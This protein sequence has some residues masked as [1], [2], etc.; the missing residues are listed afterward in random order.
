MDQ[1][2]AARTRLAEVLHQ[3]WGYESFLPLQEPAMK[4]V[5]AHRD[6]LVVL[7]T[8][9]GKSLCFQAPAMCLE[10]LAVVVSPLISL[11]KDQ[12]DAL[13]GC[14]VPAACVH[15]G[16]TPE[17]RRQIR[18]D[19]RAERLRLLYVA[20]ERLVQER[21]IEFLK[22]R[23]ISLIAIDEA[24]C[25]S[26]WGHDFRPEYRQLGLL[27]KLLPGV[28]IHAY[29]ATATERV[30]HDIVQQLALRD[31]EVLVGSFDRPNLV[32]RVERRNDRLSQIR[33]VMDRHRGSSGVVYCITRKE[34]DQTSE[35]LVN[36]GYR[37]RPYHAGMPDDDRRQNQDAFIEEKVETIVATVAFGMGIDKSNVRYVI[38]AGMPKSLEHYQQESG[39]AGRDGLE[40]ECCLIYSPQDVMTW[41]FMLDKDET[42]AEARRAA[43]RS[44]DAMEDFCTG[45]VCRHRALVEHF[46]QTYD[47]DNCG[48]CD[49]CLDDV[50]LVEDAVIVGQKILSCV[51]RLQQRFGGEYTAQVLAGSREQRILQAGHDR[52]STY[53]LLATEGKRAV[54]DWIEQLTAQGYLRKAG[55]FNV[56]EVTSEGRRLL[57]GETAPRLL[58]PAKK[59]SKEGRAATPDVD[60]WEGVDHGLFEALRALR[61]QLAIDQNVPP[62]VVFHDTSL[63]DMARRRPSTLAGFRQV[64]GVGEKKLADY[65]EVFVRLIAEHCQAQGLPVDITPPSATPRP[66][67]NPSGPSIAAT[68]AFPFFRQGLSTDEVAKRMGR[69]LS[70]TLGYLT[71]FIRHEKRT[72]PSPWVDAATADRIIGAA[73][74]VGLERLKPIF[75][76]LDGSV[77]YDQIRI[78]TECLRNRAPSG[79]HLSASSERR[80]TDGTRLASDVNE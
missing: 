18:D 77:P 37:A 57:K 21:M 30:R 76:A 39:R 1:S 80:S 72:D 63:R 54:R 20:P 44:V 6:S 79:E 10:G 66:V 35:A 16:N 3:Y 49:V 29:T 41:K 25:I 51:L 71:E 59:A 75:E 31:A 58:A 55:E 34:V 32:Y 7:P 17:E 38:H 14:G 15:S 36:L 23:K 28:G 13:R 69:A 52:L 50:E 42:P 2:D 68:G 12:T 56:L 5:L 60:S 67:E 8:G 11:M 46:G 4:C 19:I 22:G 62:Y 9:G 74:M 64:Q 45:L 47:R 53:G 61:Q 48:A 43:L 27:R 24:H 33:Q 65:G 78:V 73:E 70:T 40:A 26:V